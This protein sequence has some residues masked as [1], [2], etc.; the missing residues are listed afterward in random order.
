M[1]GFISEA[2]ERFRKRLILTAKGRHG[3]RD[4]SREE[5]R[6]ALEF[7]FS[8]EAHPAQV[9]AFLTAMRFKGARVEEMKGFLDAMEGAATLIAP[10]VEGL[11]N[12]NGPYDG[13][14][15][16]LNLAVAAAIVTS[17]AGV[18]VV[19][20][21]NVGLPPKD[22]VS[23][24]R[25]LEAMGI[26][27]ARDPEQVA[28][29]I[30][31][32]GFGHLHAARYLHGVERLKPI[33]EVLFYRSLL[34][35]CEVMLNPAGAK[36]SLLG[37]AH[38]IF[39]ERFAQAAGERGQERVMVV[40]GLDGGDELPLAPTPVADWKNG[41]IERYILSPTDFGLKEAKHSPCASAAET[42]ALTEATLSGR[43]DTHLDAILFNAA[44]RIQLGG[45]AD[46]VEAGLKLA[47]DI[48]SSGQAWAKLQ[49]LRGQV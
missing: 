1:N 3:A 31:Q 42:A 36:R 13:R 45:K 46:S 34:H 44:V 23:N 10:Q 7:L 16:S 47:R 28:T 39:V 11:I 8:A 12:L 21:S 6:D 4:M 27:A 26:A 20:H 9:G 2:G 49:S 14:K 24:A 15:K 41:N 18:P 30:E 17:A 38:D 29:D 33:R 40:E 19:L 37:A 5:A 22:G 48:L 43:D 32:K 35:S 25:L